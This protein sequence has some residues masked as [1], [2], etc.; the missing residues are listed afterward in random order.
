MRKEKI[1]VNIYKFDEL[2]SQAQETAIKD[3][4]E[5]L[6]DLYNNGSEFLKYISDDIAKGVEKA[7]EKS[8][9]LYTPWFCLTY[10]MQFC[11]ESI[12]KELEKEEFELNGTTF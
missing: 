6:L 5:R 2:D 7:V 4:A 1:E 12:I 9:K 3:Y 8:E 11:R 10:I